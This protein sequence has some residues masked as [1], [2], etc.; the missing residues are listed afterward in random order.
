MKHTPRELT[1]DEVRNP[2]D[3]GL[4][5]FET[6]DSL[7]ADLSIIG[8]QRAVQAIDFG[9]NIAAFGFNIYALGFAGTGRTTTIHTF[10]NQVAAG[11][12]IPP[13]VVYVNDFQEPN[14]PRAIDLP[15][16]MAARFRRD[17]QELVADLLREIPRAFES[18]DYE[19]QRQQ[20]VREMQ[21][22]RNEALAQLE[23]KATEAGFAVLKS[24]TGFVIAP[25][26]NGQVLS[27]DAY[28]QLDKA[29]QASLEERQERLQAEMADTMRLVRGVDKETKK[30]LQ[31]FD[32]QIADFAVG[33]L[34]DELRQDY[35]HLEEVGTYL[36]QVQADVVDNV[37]NFREEKD[38]ETG[39][40][41][42]VRAGQRHDLLHRYQVNLLVDNSGLEGAP[43]IFEPNPT[44]GNLAGRMEHRSELGALVTDFTMIKPGALHRARGGFLVVEMESLLANELAWDALKRTLKNRSIRI[45]EAASQLQVISTSTLEPEPIPFDAKV[46]LI[47]D[48]MTY[49]LLQDYDQDFRKLFKVQ[50]DFGDEFPR[51]PEAMQ[52]YARFVAARC[53]QE[54]LLPFDAAAIARV[55][56]FGSRL[57]E[58]QNKLSTR[59]G[60][61]ADVVREASFWAQ[62]AGRDVA[63][64]SD[65][66]KAM[67]QRTYRANRVEEE[68]QDLI[69]EGFQR[70]QVDGEAL[71][72]VNGLT[73]LSLGDHS[74]G[75]PARI[76]AQT[77]TGKEGVISVEREAKLSGRLYDKGL[78]TLTGYLGGKYAFGSPLS[79]SASISFEQL[80]DEIEGDSA[81]SSELYALLSSLSELP[82]RQGIAVT[83]SVDQQGNIQPVGGVNEKVEGYFDTC[84]RLGLTGD[85][86]VIV[87]ARNAVNLMLRADV[88]QAIA[89]GQF[90]IYPIDSIDEGIE[91][92]TAWPA[93]E[94]DEEG[95]YPE[96][97]VHGRVQERL[98]EIAD[99]LR[100]SEEEEDEDKDGALHASASTMDGAG[101]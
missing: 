63:S 26:L 10:L 50:A 77:F 76:T 16:G 90:H 3:P 15:P 97:S 54:G 2:C 59:F 68:G 1:S 88:C 35:G 47:G 49:Y 60:E 51:T 20:I 72:Q 99:N 27:P 91:I 53:H 78:L 43:V 25:V 19:T 65:V 66:E 55:V 17:M 24:A 12:P 28:L 52:S 37:D 22:R 45:E 81:S 67:E 13:D 5:G 89:E 85:Q 39:L 29:T 92:L 33:H 98:E 94:I 8:Q 11:Q 23:Q 41:G 100:E 21:E 62:R 14:R 32:R 31:E 84:R 79:L 4:F 69:A 64:A 36:S 80:Y 96:D 82:I 58:H 93:G 9:V 95:L 30:R 101:S 74:F 87:P 34:I 44:Y 71:G 7:P 48:P 73:V 61:I 57:A 38:G 40:A 83:G 70:I 42:A 46:V 56:E 6:T 75:R 86:G 18:E